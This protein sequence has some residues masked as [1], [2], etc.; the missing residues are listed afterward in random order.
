MV[1]NKSAPKDIEYITDLLYSRKPL[2]K[3]TQTEFAEYLQHEDSNSA[4]RF[5]RKLKNNDIV[6]QTGEKKTASKPVPVW[7]LDLAKLS[8]E[9]RATKY[10]EE[11]K[12]VFIN[13]LQKDGYVIDLP[14]LDDFRG[15]VE[16]IRNRIHS[17]SASS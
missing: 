5:F 3:G 17:F 14:V 10:Y 9:F 4:H 6:K 1:F 13:E 11:H 16:L 2:T 12:K 7:E 8:E 15:L